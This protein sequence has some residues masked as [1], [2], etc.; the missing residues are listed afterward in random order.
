MAFPKVGPPKPH[1]TGQQHAA[2]DWVEQRSKNLI[3]HRPRDSGQS[4]SHK[5]VE[6]VCM[7]GNGRKEQQSNSLPQC[8][9]IVM[10]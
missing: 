3:D 5:A 4:L 10:R 6:S 2:A 1:E 9:G 7:M 8:T